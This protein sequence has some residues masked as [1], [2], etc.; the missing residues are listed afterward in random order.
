M[1][2][3]EFSDWICRLR[4]HEMLFRR[5]VPFIGGTQDKQRTG[6]C[7]AFIFPAMRQVGLENQTVTRLQ[8][9]N[10]PANRVV[11]ASFQ[12]INEFL[13]GMRNRIWPAIGAWFQSNKKRYAFSQRQ[14]AAEILKQSMGELCFRSLAGFLVKH[15]F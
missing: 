12:A 13:P 10:L 15:I 8:D 14:T 3:T 6:Y 11:Q 4:C 9:I 7:L 1:F 5:D 2:A